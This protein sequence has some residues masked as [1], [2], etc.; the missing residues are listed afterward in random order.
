M[1]QLI[2]IGGSLGSLD[3]F[4]QILSLLPKGYKIPIVYIFHHSISG[5][6]GV[7]KEI[8]KNTDLEVVEISSNLKIE[9]GKVFV[10]PPDKHVVITLNKTFQLSDGELVNYCRPC[11]DLTMKYAGYTFGDKLF[12]GLLS[13][14]NSDGAKGLE[15]ILELEGKAA[16]LNPIHSSVD[17]MPN[18]AIQLIPD[19]SKFTFFE[20]RDKLTQFQ[21]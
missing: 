13:G 10:C 9:A 11:I 18:A 17:R 12:A 6:K 16:V 4:N 5:G 19:I 15:K 21:E 14:G 2:L 7:L 8:Q 1:M 20:F 3:E